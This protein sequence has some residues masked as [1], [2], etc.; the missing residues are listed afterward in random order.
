MKKGY[1]PY[2]LALMVMNGP[3]QG[4]QVVLDRPILLGRDPRSRV[5][6]DDERVSR[7]HAYVEQSGHRIIVRDLGSKN[8]TFLNGRELVEPVELKPDDQLRLGKTLILVTVVD[9]EGMCHVD[10]AEFDPNTDP[11]QLLPDTDKHLPEVQINRLA[12]RQATELTRRLAALGKTRH[13][14]WAIVSAIRKEF[15]ADG[16]GIFPI[17]LDGPPYYVEGEIDLPPNTT[18]ELMELGTKV[19]WLTSQLAGANA[20]LCFPMR[21]GESVEYLFLLQRDPSRPFYDD[22]VQLT[23][24]LVECMHILPLREIMRDGFSRQMSDHLASM[25]GSSEAMNRLRE[26]IRSFAATNVTVMI[27]GESGTGK[28][29]CARAISQLSERRYAPYVEMNCACIM[30][31]L[32]EAELFGHEKGAFTGARTRKLG[33]LELARGG[34]VFIEEIA[35]LSPLLQGKLLRALNDGRFFPM[36]SQHHVTVQARVIAATVHDPN[37]LVK[38]ERVR[39]DLYFKLN[40]IPIHIPPLR[41]RREDIPLLAEYF[42]RR[43]A[44]S[45]KGRMG[46]LPEEDMALLMSHDWPGNVRE[47]ENL[48]ERAIVMGSQS[49]VFTEEL[50]KLRRGRGDDDDANAS[51]DSLIGSE[52]TI[53]DLERRHVLAVLK[54]C[55]NNRTQAARILGINASTLWRKLKNWDSG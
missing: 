45:H 43:F 46:R 54:R 36:G 32:M 52:M 27:Q 47:L 20:L 11:P 4:Q 9:V 15:R 24:A 6:F 22:H 18:Q 21:I 26:Q 37:E 12:L 19:N 38:S 8:G 41:E 14:V 13:P 34:T 23:D 29:L 51:R 40:V 16:A 48:V 55:G 25:I 44:K 3:A 50:A 42:L 7:H 30:P 39:D 53:E 17:G 2:N 31:E 35:A 10:T 5:P 1:S 49:S 33:G 28:E